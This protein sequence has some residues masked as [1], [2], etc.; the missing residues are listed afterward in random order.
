MNLAVQIVGNLLYYSLIILLTYL[1]DA[2]PRAAHNVLRYA[3]LSLFCSR[4]LAI[5]YLDVAEQVREK[6]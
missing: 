4:L 3:L 6:L 1:C 2:M 5:E